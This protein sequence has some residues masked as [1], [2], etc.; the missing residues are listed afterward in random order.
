MITAPEE[1][2]FLPFVIFIQINS[3]RS[4][5]NGRC[6]IQQESYNES[7]P[8]DVSR[9]EAAESV[10]VVALSLG[11]GAGRDPGRQQRDGQRRHGEDGGGKPPAGQRQS[12]HLHHAPHAHHPHHLALQAPPRPVPSRNGTRHDLR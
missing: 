8:A 4:E 7:P 12:A 5:P 10:A 6:N 2:V 3:L 9:G 1:S 11:A